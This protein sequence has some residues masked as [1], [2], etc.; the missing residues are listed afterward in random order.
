M[1][2]MITDSVRNDI[3]SANKTLFQILGISTDWLDEKVRKFNVQVSQNT[4]REQV[5]CNPL[6]NRMLLDR[7]RS[8]CQISESIQRL[9]IYYKSL[10]EY[11]ERFWNE[12]RVKIIGDDYSNFHTT[13]VEIGLHQ[14]L[15]SISE[16]DVCFV[17]TQ[18]GGSKRPD[19][20]LSFKGFEI[21][22][23]LKSLLSPKIYMPDGVHFGGTGISEAV[24]RKILDAYRKP[25]KAG[26]VNK[27]GKPSLIFVD[28]T[29]CEE[30]TIFE[31]FHSLSVAESQLIFIESFNNLKNREFPV[32]PC[33]LL[34]RCNAG[35]FQVTHILPIR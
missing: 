6:L 29:F 30:S 3:S 22:A 21:E 2:Q 27:A 26:Q 11:K 19:Y 16:L 33:L 31:S 34:C 9:A 12:K 13:L 4:L 5:V 23:E 32:D 35:T 18:P 8:Q 10:P 24:A 14:A 20:L 25:V 7:A 17:D 28:I 1:Y 15:S